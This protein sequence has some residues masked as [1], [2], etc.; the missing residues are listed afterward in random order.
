M[1]VPEHSFKD[2]AQVKQKAGV[3]VEDKGRAKAKASSVKAS[4]SKSSSQRGVRKC[5]AKA[6]ACKTAKRVEAAKGETGAFAASV[7][8]CAGISVVKPAI[9]IKAVK[10]KSAKAKATTSK[11]V[12]D[13]AKAPPASRSEGFAAGDWVQLVG[14]E[15]FVDLN[16]RHARLLHYTPERCR[17]QV[18]IDGEPAVKNV[19]A[20]N[21]KKLEVS[22]P[23]GKSEAERKAVIKDEPGKTNAATSGTSVGK[24][25]QKGNISTKAGASK[26]SAFQKTQSAKAKPA[27]KGDQDTKADPSA[28]SDEVA[29]E[30][31]PIESKK[32]GR[33]SVAKDPEAQARVQKPRLSED[34]GQMPG[35]TEVETTSPQR[36][37]SSIKVSDT[38]KSPVAVL[39]RRLSETVD[40]PQMPALTTSAQASPAGK[41]SR[42]MNTKGSGDIQMA[43]DKAL[44][45]QPMTQQKLAPEAQ[46]KEV[47]KAG[48]K[49][50]PTAAPKAVPKVATKAVPK[51]VPKVATKA[52][53]KAVPKVATKAAPKAEPTAEAKAGA[54]AASKAE[55]KAVPEA[56]PSPESRTEPK[57]VPKAAKP[58]GKDA[59]HAKDKKPEA[60]PSRGKGRDVE[61][62]D[63]DDQ[64]FDDVDEL[65]GEEE[66]SD[67][68]EAEAV[69]DDE[70]DEEFEWEPVG[71]IQMPNVWPSPAPCPGQEEF[72]GYASKALARAGLGT[73]K[74]PF[75]SLGMRLHQESAAFLLHPESPIQR[76]L[77]DHATGTG[78]TLV[79]LRMLDNYFD[80]PRPKVA[81]F[82]KDRVCD[83]FYQELLKWPTRWRHYFCFL[84]PAEA[85][86]ASGAKDWRRK[87]NDVWDINNERLRAEAKSRGIRLEKLIREVID[88]IRDALEMKSSIHGGKVKTKPAR[89]FLEEHP[90]AP[91]PRAPLRAFRYTTAGGAAADIGRDGWPKS[92]ILKVGF[93][94]QEL[95]PYS[96]KVVI[97]DECHNLVRPNQVY[98]EQL[99][100]LRDL[101]QSSTRT[102]LAGFTGTPV[103]NDASEGRRLL[104]VI[105]G[106]ASAA[107]GDEGFVSS[108]HARASDDFP[109][110]VPV[111]GLP[112][113]VL[114]EGM[115]KALTKRH[116]LHGEALKRYLLKEVEFQI[117]PRLLLLPQEKRLYRLANYCNLHVHYGGYWGRNRAAL[118]ANVK[119]HAPKFYSVAK[120][121]S[122]S[123]EKAVVMLTRE[124]GYKALLEVLRKT[125]KK[126][127]F[128]VAT[129]DELGDF[130]D[131]KRNLRGERFRV[132]VAETSQAGEGV[133]F[134]HARRLYLVDV[135]MR[136]SDLVQRASRCVRLGGHE[137]L[138]ASERELA[139]EMHLV[140]LPSFLRKGPSSLIYREL[141][142]AKEVMSIPGSAIEEA[143][144]A[145]LAELKQRGVKTLVDMQRVLQA[146]DGKNLIDLLTE[147]ALEKLG[148]TNAAPARP[149]AMAL[150]RL[151]KGGDDL[152][153]LEKALLKQASVKTAD[154][155]LLDN[156]MDKSVELLKPLEDMRLQAVD[157]SLLA[158]LGDPPKAP[159]PRNTAETNQQVAVEE[160]DED[161]DKKDKEDALDLDAGDEP[162]V[163]T[164]PPCLE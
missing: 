21:I 64:L 45:A 114:H 60:V 154:A 109:R 96:G 135:P 12:R 71:A 3:K 47:P 25:I 84:K 22:T 42:R 150:W 105:K 61:E 86:L 91:M 153:A 62:D 13:K 7:G 139:I 106:D 119:D 156:L 83:N 122:K 14:L 27:S 130:N 37:R 65:E 121:I 126:H 66:V 44:Q 107:M 56:V 11:E 157:R 147:T 15:A 38:D 49:A 161:D 19:R 136:H 53:P 120:S 151:R 113:G 87:K 20:E 111:Q 17:W 125:G 142:N 1:S 76:L 149:F 57:A 129:L 163:E 164:G 101:L 75:A 40:E 141:L 152:V 63:D 144:D 81:I 158:S 134:R 90:G 67:W 146:D 70:E 99:G 4:S 36:V 137:D 29:P 124:M 33:Q 115:L 92:P 80:D 110:E 59:V 16:G 140:Q 79:M 34:Q 118:I 55:P 30:A 39:I 50:A 123:P 78:K 132:M 10:G 145:C 100:R 162:D 155:L 133:Q 128:K 51:A 28:K 26:A 131:A 48:P 103:G 108:F 2:A 9:A 23:V 138:P 73:A 102:V 6:I 24:A 104:E 52:V 69:G 74:S 117:T 58:E 32:R 93:D 116:S 18:Q 94:T 112:D 98:E 160:E 5:F 82:P 127:G 95:N 89:L 77:V 35:A 159:P 143:T 43:G 8:K 54:K 97:M 41:P 72:S 46:P 31:K 148:N 88:S 85:S 68:S